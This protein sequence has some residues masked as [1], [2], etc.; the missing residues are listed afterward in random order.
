MALL[1]DDDVQSRLQGLDGWERNGDELRREFRFD[2]FKGSI[3]FVNRITAPAE[4]MNHHPD[5]AISWNTV[6]VAL[7]T[8][9]EG[10]ITENDFQLASRI[11][12][13]A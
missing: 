12:S 10:G 9:S 1:S 6:T 13:L 7:S 2:D 8:H 3:D 4:E 5:L 11:D